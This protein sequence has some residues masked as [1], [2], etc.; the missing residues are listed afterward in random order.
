MSDARAKTISQMNRM[1]KEHLPFVFMIDFLFNEPVVLTEEEAVS[2]KLLYNLRGIKN[3]AE[4]VI[5]D[6]P[7]EFSKYPVTFQEYK[8]GFDI[9]AGNI[10]RGNTYL[11]NYT[12]P[13]RIETNYS[14]KEI[15][16][17]A[18]SKFKA[19][20]K[21]NFVFFSPEIFTEIRDG[22]ICSY[23]MKGT[24]DANIPDAEKIILNDKK[25]LAEHNTIVDLI[26]NDLNI[27]AEKVKVERFRYI[28]KII[29]NQKPL[30]QVSSKISGKLGRNYNESIG[31]IIA[32]LLPAG[33]VTGAP[34]KK[35]VEI[36]LEAERYNRGYYTGIFGRFDGT[37]LDSCVMIRFIE[38]TTEGYVFKSG[39][40]ITMFSDALSE[41]N[42]MIDKVYVPVI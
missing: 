20:W 14:L 16:H 41:Y 22:I 8:T 33:S 7:L 23:P 35:T 13:T 18:D 10:R 31:N 11:L 39:G 32:E 19:L 3:Y 40:G 38:N 17:A 9:V 30:L 26:R 27:V 4:K 42:E 24:I 36:I 12:A 6:K 1:G 29:T 2:E 28:D 15:F 34:K 37:N 21:N 5:A 25:E